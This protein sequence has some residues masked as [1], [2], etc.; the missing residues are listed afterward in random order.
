MGLLQRFIQ[1]K[2]LE[3]AIVAICFQLLTSG[4]ALYLGDRPLTLIVTALMVLL[5]IAVGTVAVEQWRARNRITGGEFHWGTEVKKGLIF[6][7]GLRSHEDSGTVMKMIRTIK[8]TY[9]GFIAT[10]ATA[11]NNVTASIVNKCG[12]KDGEWR[13]KMVEPTN[14]TEIRDDTKHL[15]NWML[16]LGVSSSEILIDLTGGTAV[17]SVGAFMAADEAKVDTVYVYSDFK[18]N[19]PIEGSQRPLRI[20]S[21]GNG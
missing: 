11:K 3:I 1:E 2:W 19:K 8:P 20:A 14:V 15:I 7:L 18:D 12:L 9:L 10:Q 17:V 16:S 5:L 4:V 21:Y 13:E 6:T